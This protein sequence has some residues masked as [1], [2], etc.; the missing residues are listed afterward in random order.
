M[1]ILN[2]NKRSYYSEAGHM[3]TITAVL[4]AGDIGDY[5]VYV[6]CGSDEYVARAGDKISF[7]EATCHFIGLQEKKYRER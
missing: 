3:V 7:K 6:G 2:T 4:V 1:K 5:A